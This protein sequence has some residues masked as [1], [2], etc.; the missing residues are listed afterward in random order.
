M[1]R[2]SALMFG[3]LVT[4]SLAAPSAFAEW[5]CVH[6]L[7]GKF[8]NER[9]LRPRTTWTDEYRFPWGLE[10]RM[11][12]Q[13]KVGASPKTY[14]TILY[15]IPVQLE[16]EYSKLRI[17]FT[18]ENWAMIKTISVRDG[19]WWEIHAQ[20]GWWGHTSEWK[21]DIKPLNFAK[22]HRFTSSV[23]ITVEASNTLDTYW[24]KGEYARLYIHGICL[25]N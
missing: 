13:D 15:S 16:D 19:G 11:P 18:T 1:K 25:G 4:T 2:V 24:D 8:Q 7:D 3:L 5:V 10:F 6:G 17:H 22:P 20:E 9:E 23:G 14:A 21:E 12:P